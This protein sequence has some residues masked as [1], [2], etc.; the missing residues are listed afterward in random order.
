M[1]QASSQQEAS[2][3][4]F[5]PLYAAYFMLFTS[6][7]HSFTRNTAALHYSETVKF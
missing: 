6:L 1:T 7:A 5:F 4:F 2:C 3:K